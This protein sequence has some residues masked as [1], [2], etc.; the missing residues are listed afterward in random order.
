MTFEHYKRAVKMMGRPSWDALIDEVGEL[1]QDKSIEEVCDVLH[2]IIRLV[3]LP[4]IVSWVVARPTASKH[5]KRVAERGCPRSER[6]CKLLGN[7]CCCKKLEE[8]EHE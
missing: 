2:T 4:P 7:D 5:A 1:I 8:I 3:G 6:M